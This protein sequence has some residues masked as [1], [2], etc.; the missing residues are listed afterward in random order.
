M[1]SNIQKCLALTNTTGSEKWTTS[2]NSKASQNSPNANK[3]STLL[4][5]VSPHLSRI[6]RKMPPPSV[7]LVFAQLGASQS[8]IPWQVCDSCRDPTTRL[9]T[10][11]HMHA[12]TTRMQR[13]YQTMIPPD[14]DAHAH[15]T[16]RP[17]PI[18][19]HTAVC[20]PRSHPTID[21]TLPAWMART[22]PRVYY[23]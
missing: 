12:H 7:P 14:N 6:L 19:T 22:A 2:K 10:L 9:C 1:Y 17:V 3:P 21:F 15:L 23:Y 13:C 5:L 16:P 8:S 20:R 18:T 11:T 4:S